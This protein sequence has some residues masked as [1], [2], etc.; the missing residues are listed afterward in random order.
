MQIET[1]MSASVWEL[2]ETRIVGSCGCRIAD[3]TRQQITKKTRLY[4]VCLSNSEMSKRC[5]GMWMVRVCVWL[6]LVLW[7]SRSSD[8]YLTTLPDHTAHAWLVLVSGST[9]TMTWSCF[10]TWFWHVVLH[11][12]RLN[13]SAAK[14]WSV[15]LYLSWSDQFSGVVLVCFYINLKLKTASRPAGSGL[16][17]CI[18]PSPDLVTLP[19]LTYGSTLIRTS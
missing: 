3:T 16:W 9:F 2:T 19:V 11:Q 12:Q 1:N 7:M 10:H 8:Q 15:V 17:F 18:Y 6:C 5:A 4:Y 14:F 13:T